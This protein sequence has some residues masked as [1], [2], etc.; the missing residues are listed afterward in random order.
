MSCELS[1][2]EK[3]LHVIKD[4]QTSIFS[5]VIE[6][7]GNFGFDVLGNFGL[8]GKDLQQVGEGCV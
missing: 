1:A 6:D 8:L 4:N 5:Q 2:A 3:H 7:L